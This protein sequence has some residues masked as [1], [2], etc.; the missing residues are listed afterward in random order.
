MPIHD[1][2]GILGILTVYVIKL[3]DEA[4]AFSR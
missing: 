1:L 2:A 4:I 3:I